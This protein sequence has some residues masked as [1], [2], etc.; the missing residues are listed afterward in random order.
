VRSAWMP[1]AAG[2]ASALQA[3]TL[4]KGDKNPFK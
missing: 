3:T 1:R 4:I 2:D